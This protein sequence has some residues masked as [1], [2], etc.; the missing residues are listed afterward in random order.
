MDNLSATMQ[1]T[2]YNAHL[3]AA[4]SIS[5]NTATC[6]ISTDVSKPERNKRKPLYKEQTRL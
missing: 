6:L 3:A 1:R 2:S 4:R 5:I